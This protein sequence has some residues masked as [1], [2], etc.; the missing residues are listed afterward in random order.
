MEFLK[1]NLFLIEVDVNESLVCYDCS[2]SINY[3]GNFE[4]VFKN[5]DLVCG[6]ANYTVCDELVTNCFVSGFL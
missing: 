6:T 3:T 4:S 1:F 5:F 2:R